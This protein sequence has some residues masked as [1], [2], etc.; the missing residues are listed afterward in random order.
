[1]DGV[2]GGAGAGGAAGAVDEGFGFV[3]E[4]E[5]DDAVNVVDVD[6]SGGEV[7][8]DE[9]GGLGGAELFEAL[10]AQGLGFFAVENG[11]G[12]VGLLHAFG[13]AIGAAACSAEDEGALGGCL[14]EEP[15]EEGEFIVFFDVVEGVLD[16]GGEGGVGFE[17]EGCGFLEDVVGEFVGFGGH[18]GG[19][20]EGL[21]LGGEL[22]EEGADV[23]G[24]AEVEH[25]VGFVDDDVV[26]FV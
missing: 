13:E 22:F 15:F 20:E 9:N 3:G 2:S 10:V 21:A 25:A 16:G 5:V 6:A 17:L 19:E 8:G 11:G 1:M 4:V 26:G 24:E 23:G 12:E 18:G 14:G 7:G